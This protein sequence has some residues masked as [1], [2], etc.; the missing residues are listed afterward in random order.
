MDNK[1]NNEDKKDLFVFTIKDMQSINTKQLY[2]MCFG[3]QEEPFV[4]ELRAE[5]FMSGSD[6][7]SDGS[8]I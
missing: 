2:S 8:D 7:D 1:T 3:N 4:L 6:E 5:I